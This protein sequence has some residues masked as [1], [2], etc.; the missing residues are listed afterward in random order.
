MGCG[1]SSSSLNR[2]DSVETEAPSESGEERLA[3]ANRRIL[4]HWLEVARLKLVVESSTMTPV[5]GVSTPGFGAGKKSPPH[6]IEC[7]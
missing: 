3:E 7:M 5:F 6:V 1:P 2:K 4:K